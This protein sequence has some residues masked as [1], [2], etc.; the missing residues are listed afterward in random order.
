MPDQNNKETLKSQSDDLYRAYGRFAV[1]FEHICHATH[2]AITFLLH[3]EG[4]RN[5]QVANIFLAGM[6]ADPLR[7]LFVSL[8]GEVKSLNKA[9]QQIFDNVINRFQKLTEKRNDIIHGTWF[10]GWA[11][12]QDT[13][14]SNAAGFKHHRNK[15][16]ATVKA[17]DFSAADFDKLTDE[18]ETLSNLMSRISGCFNLDKSLTNNFSV[19]QDG[20][21][22][23]PG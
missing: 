1:Q 23:L 13:E 18:A 16:G 4:L 22:S 20:T 9:E 19:S 14:F 15:D 6:T 5:Q 21:V 11:N 10:I 17:F 3:K 7:T 8:V 12:E 2:N